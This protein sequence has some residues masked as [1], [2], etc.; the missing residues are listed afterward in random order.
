MNEQG[1][2]RY[3]Q[4]FFLYEVKVIHRRLSGGRTAPRRVTRCV[5]DA[6]QLSR[7]R[8]TKKNARRSRA[9]AFHALPGE[10]TP[11][12]KIARKTGLTPSQVEEIERRALAKLR[13]SPE[14]KEA[15]AL[16]EEDGMPLVDYIR[17]HIRAA[18]ESREA[19]LM[20]QLQIEIMDWWQVHDL[21]MTMGMRRDARQARRVIAH[22]RQMLVKE[23]GCQRQ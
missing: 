18:V 23:L 6:C 16:Y 17:G 19:D 5:C 4:Q 3:C 12:S 15:F 10:F 20:L 13:G 9:C 14:L 7:Q 11:R 2:C 22:G 8:W 21:A 1:R